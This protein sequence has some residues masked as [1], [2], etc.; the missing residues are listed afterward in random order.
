[1]ALRSNR[2]LRWIIL[3]IVG[4]FIQSYIAPPP[5]AAAAMEFTDSVKASLEKTAEAVGGK[6]KTRLIKQYSD[7]ADLQ[8]KINAQ[9]TKTTSLR[10]SNETQLNKVRKQITNLDAD[11]I[12]KLDNQAKAARS[13]LQPLLDL[14]SSLNKQ[15]AAVKALKD[16][17]LYK[18]LKQKADAMKPAIN[19][20][21]LH[22]RNRNAELK[23]AK[24]ERTRKTKE[25]RAVLSQIDAIKIKLKAERSAISSKNKSISTEWKNFKTA[26]KN[27][28]AGRAEDT[29]NRLGNLSKQIL[30]HKQNMYGLE[31]QISAI[32]KKASARLP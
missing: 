8:K 25:I 29:L 1:M 5:P 32:I 2:I 18:A 22:I 6:A 23:T 19:L 15:A 27:K 13:K 14:H 24:S 26:L 17:S 11:K 28:D 30:T 20:A 31:A 12:L 7:L 4:V 3:F 21:R 9:D 16:K 10:L